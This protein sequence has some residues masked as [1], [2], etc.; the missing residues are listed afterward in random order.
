MVNYSESGV[1]IKLGDSSSKI[2]YT[3]ARETWKNRKGKLGEIITPFDDFSGIRAMDVSKLPEGTFMGMNFDGIGTKVEIAERLGKHDTLAFD[4]FAMV[5]DDAVVRGGEPVLVGSI[6]DVNKLDLKIIK[7]LAKGYVGAAK[8][9]NVAVIN[10]EIAELGNRIGGFGEYN[11]NWGAAVVWFA[12]KKNM[13]TGKEIGVGDKLIAFEEK[14]FRSNGLSL[15]RKIMNGEWNKRTLEQALTPSKIYSK[16]VVEMFGKLTGVAHITGGG[17]PGKVGRMLKPSGFGA[18]LDNL[19]EPCELM[20][21]CIEK[22]KMEKE[23]AYQTWNM[24]NGMIVSTQYPEEI[25]SIAKKNK[26]NAK[27]CGEVVKE[28]GIKII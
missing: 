5:C 25:I 20:E 16:A 23:E 19:F 28:K 14:G 4:L 21:Y 1:N 7:Q 15:V 3:A 24:G 17:I 27:I 9:G 11:Y 26:I 2:M 18:K 10:G 8:E 22:G 6:L 13:L 12:N